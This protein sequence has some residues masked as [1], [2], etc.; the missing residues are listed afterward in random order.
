MGFWAGGERI[1][2]HRALV[3]P[4]PER[5]SVSYSRALEAKGG[6][7]SGES[8]PFSIVFAPFGDATER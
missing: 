4:F 7:E 1:S 3:E 6:V 2:E 8:T 5:T